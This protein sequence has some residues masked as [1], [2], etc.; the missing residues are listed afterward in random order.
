MGDY[1]YKRIKIK[2]R[3]IDRHRLVMEKH[4]GRKLRPDEIVHHINGDPTDD[5]I[6]NLEITNRSEHAKHHVDKKRFRQ[7]QEDVYRDNKKKCNT[8][9]KNW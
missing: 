3:L 6:E 1:P 4:L 7:L 5:R 9:Y 2:G 8:I